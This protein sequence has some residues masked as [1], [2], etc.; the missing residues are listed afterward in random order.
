MFLARPADRPAV[1]CCRYPDGCVY[2]IS[3]NDLCEGHLYRWQRVGKPALADL[4]SA[5]R[6]RVTP[7]FSVDGLPPLL[8]L[9]FQY[10]LQ[11]RTDERASRIL[12][13]T[14][15]CVTRLALTE[16]VSSLRDR[17]LDQWRGRASQD[18]TVR[19]LLG[20]A[21]RALAD[22]DRPEDEYEGDVWRPEHLGF[23]IEERRGVSA[24]NFTAITQEWLRDKA[25]RWTKVKLGHGELRTVQSQVAVFKCFSRFLAHA[26]S[27]RQDDPTV[28]DRAVLET[29]VGWLHRHVNDNK[30]GRGRGKPF[31]AETRIRHLSTM[32][33]FFAYWHRYGWEPALS[34]T[35]RIFTDDYPRRSGLKANFI[36]E[37][38][39]EQI[40]SEENLALLEPE[41]R[42]MVLICRD[43]GLRIGEALTLKT[44]CLKQTPSGRWAL[45]HYK[46][47]DKSFRAIP[48]S[49]VVVEA[50][51]EQHQRVLRRFDDGCPWL[52]PRAQMNP[53]G[54]HHMTY[55]TITRRFD[56]WLSRIRLVDIHGRPARVTWHQFRHTL[57][58]RMANAGVS[59]RTIREVLGHTSWEM[60]EHYSRISDE[61][62][63]REYEEKYEVRFNLKGEAV[64]VRRDSDLSAVEW[65][66]EKIGRRLHAVAGGWCGRHIARPCPKT[67]ADGCYVCEDFQTDQKFLP[68]HEDTLLRARE[69]Q[70]TTEAAGRTRAAETNARLA[71]SVEH[72]IIRITDEESD[73]RAR[74]P[75]ADKPD[76]TRTEGAA[77]AS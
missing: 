47:K 8:T 64:R 15:G 45:V 67:A 73:L 52:F 77:D 70:A 75:D 62:L 34:P 27:D 3:S 53:D 10:L 32:A 14:W 55:T 57:G 1:G 50:I 41:T 76:H 59:G 68:I 63:R 20:T 61:T 16:G 2:P 39:M 56:A 35:T 44:D 72:L 33:D 22:L 58:T 28:L 4:P 23:S 42:T 36:D 49:R 46:S 43:E 11:V 51:R 7:G 19:G 71:D 25:K 24:L 37:Y 29:Y 6:D 66:A 60:Q 21:L 17:T 31:S 54:R 40:E 13:A 38:L 5:V 48:A 30:A 9:E 26:Y 18:P 12:Q 69:L 74:T 65:L